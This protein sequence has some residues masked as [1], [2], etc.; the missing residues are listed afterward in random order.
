MCVRKSASVLVR[1]SMVAIVSH[2]FS[3]F[4]SVKNIQGADAIVA[5]H[6][7]ELKYTVFR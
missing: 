5:P 4:K 1:S 7:N 3:K 2:P 6:S